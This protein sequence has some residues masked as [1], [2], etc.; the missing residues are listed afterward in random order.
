MGDDDG[1]AFEVACWLMGSVDG[2]IRVY[3]L[4]ENILLNTK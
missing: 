2:M 1:L 3:S 4:L